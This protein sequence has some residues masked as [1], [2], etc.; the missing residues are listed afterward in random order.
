MKED[1]YKLNDR[2]ACRSKKFDD[3]VLSIFL[4][5]ILPDL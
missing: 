3:S 5:Y 1:P 4:Y 2:N